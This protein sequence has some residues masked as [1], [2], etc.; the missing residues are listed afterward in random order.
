MLTAF[1]SPTARRQQRRVAPQGLGLWRLMTIPLVSIPLLS[2]VWASTA[3]ATS[4]DA[5]VPALPD[6]LPGAELDWVPLPTA[7]PG[8][9]CHGYYVSPA[10]DLPDR[11]LPFADA[12][13][14][15]ESDQADYDG[16]GGVRLKGDVQLRKGPVMLRSDR[17]EVS[18]DQQ[19]L[20]LQGNLTMRRPGAL[21]RGRSGQ[22]DNEAGTLRLDEAHFVLHQQRLRGDAGRLEQDADGIIYLRNSRFTT[23]AP[24]DN[25]WQLIAGDLALNQ[26]SGFG[27]AHDVRLEVADIPVFYWPWL[28][29]PIDDRRHSGLLF[30]RLGWS[31][32]N[33]FDYTQ[34]V[35]LNLAPNMDAT[36]TPRWM[37]SRGLMLGTEFRYLA[38]PVHGGQ[39]NYSFINEDERYG[40][41]DRWLFNTR[42]EGLITGSWRY[43]VD[44]NQASDDSYL[45]DFG[46][47]V[48]VGS[49]DDLLQMIEV[50]GQAA[51]WQAALRFR[52]Y[53][54]LDPNSDPF[55]RTGEGKGYQLFDLRQ[56]RRASVQ[57]YYQM[58][59]LEVSRGFGLTE[60]VSSTVLFET[61]RFDPL[62]P[63]D[64]QVTTQADPEAYIQ[65]WGTPKSTR[66]YGQASLLGE[67]H[68]T[69]GYLKPS[70]G[71][72][73]IR[74]D[75][76]P[77]E[78]SVLGHG[79]NKTPSA[80][81]PMAVLDTGL[82]FEREASWWGSD[83][84]QTLEPRL[85]G[86]HIPDVDQHDL[87]PIF[88]WS[89]SDITAESLFSPDRFSGRDRVG[90]LSRVTLGVTQ[91][92]LNHDD[93]REQF[94][95]ML[96]KAFYLRD[97][98]VTDSALPE[99]HPDHPKHQ[100]RDQRAYRYV[101]NSSSIVAQAQWQISDEFQLRQT[102]LWDDQINRLDRSSTHLR[103]QP[104]WGLMS[105]GYVQASNYGDV[106]VGPSPGSDQLDQY[107]HSRDADE[108]FDL[109]MVWNVT[110][111]VSVFG[112]YLHDVP[113]G[114]SL[115][116]MA[117][118]SYD[119]CCWQVQLLYRDWVS[120]TDRPAYDVS[121]GDYADRD[122]DHGVFIRFVLKGLGGIG[123]AT[124]DI[125]SGI[126]GYRRKD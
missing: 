87:P 26:A 78:D 104:D 46:Q 48:D 45:D 76:D 42:H 16:Q 22:V 30:P 94:R 2:V 27:D 105:I 14:F 65:R 100:E 62:L 20:S 69:W 10:L 7:Q 75:L 71:V 106:L 36:V 90:D 37:Q 92:W 6:P 125:I 43:R 38:S 60:H 83:Y 11:D 93:G 59:Q 61:V 103:W 51:G 119:S 8:S 122:R 113:T 73:Y 13:L 55:E 64:E 5:P 23:C 44:F 3:Q 18:P 99:D 68:Q 118:L 97:R 84:T 56:G 117:G 74:Q 95:F 57:E 91:R 9:Q 85:Y 114:D 89:E 123:Q 41:R 28:R 120:N 72:T 109:G 49:G 1:R 96:A 40:D 32:D 110:P 112:R 116:Q 54:K 80:T 111:Q 35:Y 63:Q 17:A 29:F 58:P 19:H 39:F 70:V 47:N 121:T 66:L 33:G 4:P 108:Q 34:P 24:G 52:G 86:V 98:F 77:Y 67:W 50:T 107:S 21:L 101:R 81:V 25:A 82:Y 126:P 12:R 124:D 15:A 79:F 115:E 53:Q 31:G 88:D 102:L